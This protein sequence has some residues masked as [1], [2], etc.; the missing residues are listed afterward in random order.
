VIPLF[1]ILSGHKYVADG[2][3]EYIRKYLDNFGL[4]PCPENVCDTCQQ[5]QQAEELVHPNP[6]EPGLDFAQIDQQTEKP[7][8]SYYG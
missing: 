3:Q 1:G 8:Q 4:M 2:A 5:Y 7:I 6:G